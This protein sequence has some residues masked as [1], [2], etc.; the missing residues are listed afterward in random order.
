MDSQI[1]SVAVATAMATGQETSLPL[2]YITVGGRR[3]HWIRLLRN[4]T[5]IQA[6]VRTDT[7]FRKAGGLWNCI[8]A[9][10]ESA[11]RF[12]TFSLRFEARIIL[13]EAPALLN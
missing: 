6:W 11:F 3:I 1:S 2:A 7:V 10:H 13:S 9:F 8:H 4:E 5:R 12:Q